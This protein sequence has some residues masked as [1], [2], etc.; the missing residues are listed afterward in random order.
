[1]KSHCTRVLGWSDYG[2]VGLRTTAIKIPLP[3]ILD[4]TLKAHSPEDNLLRDN[5]RH[6]QSHILE[7]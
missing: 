1:M 7:G 2:K 5:P 3:P 6:H 4:W